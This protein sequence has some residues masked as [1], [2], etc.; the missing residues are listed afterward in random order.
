MA[1]IRGSL[2]AER[3]RQQGDR[4]GSMGQ[5]EDGGGGGSLAAE[6]RQQQGD[7][8][9]SAQQSESGGNDGGRSVSLPAVV[10]AA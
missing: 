1:V 4:C 8:C 9:S 7:G 5:S 2:A 10:A 6:Q 3:R